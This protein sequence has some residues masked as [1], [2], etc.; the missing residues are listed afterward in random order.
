MNR[1]V[2]VGARG[3]RNADFLGKLGALHAI[4]HLVRIASETTATLRGSSIGPV[5]RS[6]SVINSI[7][8]VAAQA[9][10]A[11]FLI[12]R[13]LAGERIPA[14]EQEMRDRHD[15]RTRPDVRVEC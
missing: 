2:A 11:V 7:A 1:H 10:D 13:D 4:A 14:I 3:C 8:V 5:T 12:T 6:Q 9:L 15:K